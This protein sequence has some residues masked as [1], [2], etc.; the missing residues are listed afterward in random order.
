MAVMAKKNP[1]PWTAK[2]VKALRE[3][4]DLT[5]AEA[6]AL[7]GVTRRQWAAWEAG[8]SKPSGPASKLLQLLSD[9]N[10]KI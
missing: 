9:R 6:A 1:T 4:L 3:R 7:V 2:R 10:G 8:E 5:Q